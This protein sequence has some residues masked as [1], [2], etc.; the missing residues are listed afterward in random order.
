MPAANPLADGAGAQATLSSSLYAPGQA[1]VGGSTNITV[2]GLV[3][4]A[5]LVILGLHVLGFRFAFDA[6][7]GRRG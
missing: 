4:F 1:T 7:V 3:G 6:S 5:L 2:A